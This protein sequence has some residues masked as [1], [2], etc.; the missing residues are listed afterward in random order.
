MK[1]R[2]INF[3]KLGILLFGISLFL[4]NCEK[5]EL[6]QVNKNTSL[7]KTVSKKESASFLTQN[8]TLAKGYNSYL[9][10]DI[11]KIS[12]ENITNSESKLTVIPAKV[13]GSSLY[14]RILLLKINDTIKSVVYNMYP[15]LI[16]ETPYFSGQV[17]LTN[18]NGKVKKAFRYLN[19]VMMN[20]YTLK[21]NNFYNRST[22]DASAEC[23]MFCGHDSSDQYCICNTQELEGFEITASNNT[24]DYVP[25]AILYGED[26]GTSGSS[27]TC[28]VNCNGWDDGGGNND[29]LQNC[30]ENEVYNQAT[31]KCI[32]KAGFIKNSSGDCI[33]DINCV[34]LKRLVKNDSIGSN[35]VPMVNQLRNKLGIGNKEW[36]IAYKNKWINGTRKNVPDEN[37]IQEGP[38]DTRSHFTSGNIWVGQMHTH[39]QGTISIFSWLDIRA[40]KT[41]HTDSHDNFND[42]VFVMSVTPNNLTYTIRVDNIQTLISKIQNDMDNANGNNDDEKIKSIM[43]EMTEDYRKSSNL[44]QTFLDLYGSY[45]ISLYKTTDANLNNWKQL[46]L[47]TNDNQI[48]NETPCN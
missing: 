36:S 44:E 31:N 3:I 22:T 11:S 29:N 2:K 14:S 4:F 21:Q 15:N 43:K 16:Q 8:K 25:I 24:S 37:G 28:E 46:E 27:N 23:R 48:V 45:G 10:Y 33:K 12:F 20:V 7:L 42:E 30:G 1:K 18:L 39:P 6:N 9:T 5:G 26:D 40:L 13:E 41:L 47:D 38:S 19:G 32:C 35:I 34:R 17:T